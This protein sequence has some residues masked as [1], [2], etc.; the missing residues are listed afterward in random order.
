MPRYLGINYWQ[1]AIDQRREFYNRSLLTIPHYLEQIDLY[2][3]QGTVNGF[4]D[5]Q[6]IKALEVF[7]DYDDDKFRSFVKIPCSEKYGKIE[8]FNDTGTNYIDDKDEIEVIPSS[9]PE[10]QKSTQWEAYKDV[11]ENKENDK[12]LETFQREDLDMFDEMLK[13]KDILE[14]VLC[15]EN[16]Y[17]V[18]LPHLQQLAGILQPKD[19]KD[20]LCNSQGQQYTEQMIFMDELKLNNHAGNPSIKADICDNKETFNKIKLEDGK[21]DLEELISPI[22]CKEDNY[23][24]S[25]IQVLLENSQPDSQSP[26]KSNL[27]ICDEMKEKLVTATECIENDFG[28]SKETIQEKEFREINEEGQIKSICLEDTLIE[29]PLFVTESLSIESY[30]KTQLWNFDHIQSFAMPSLKT[31]KLLLRDTE[32][33]FLLKKFWQQEKYHDEDLCIRLQVPDIS[34]GMLNVYNVMIEMK[35]SIQI[36]NEANLGA[37]ELK[38]SWDPFPKNVCCTSTFDGDKLTLNPRKTCMIPSK[39]LEDYKGILLRNK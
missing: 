34:N 10:S 12:E 21:N 16:N 20:P 32:E 36:T 38:L 26:M 25:S 6:S 14:E 31:K 35:T 8:S 28:G 22:S 37:A 29:S 4:Y 39:S 9:N 1:Q 30:T 18:K 33:K 27:Q 17:K 15:I 24:I 23:M 2:V 11:L 5:K 3:H 7:E 19:I 13:D